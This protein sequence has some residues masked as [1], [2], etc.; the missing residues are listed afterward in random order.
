MR[1][2]VLVYELTDGVLIIFLSPFT[3][4]NTKQHPLN[5]QHRLQ[6]RYISTE[7]AATLRFAEKCGKIWVD[8]RMG[9][10]WGGESSYKRLQNFRCSVLS[11]MVLRP[12]PPVR[13]LF[14][15][16]SCTA[17]QEN[18]TLSAYAFLITQTKYTV[19]N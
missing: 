18:S 2:V 17:S 1:Y 14:Q 3:S 4:F 7:E 11:R 15:L 16:L 10:K 6:N 8:L 12:A 9:L 5:Q 13:Q 19:P